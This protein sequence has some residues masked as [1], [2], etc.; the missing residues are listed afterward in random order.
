MIG[1]FGWAGAKR[2]PAKSVFCAGDGG[3]TTAGN[4]NLRAR[5][6]PTTVLLQFTKR[7]HRYRLHRLKRSS[8]HLVSIRSD[9]V[10][11]QVATLL[12]SACPSEVCTTPRLRFIRSIC[13]AWSCLALP[14]TC[15]FPSAG[16]GSSCA[17]IAIRFEC[18]RSS[19]RDSPIAVRAFC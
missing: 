13:S 18:H 17:A 12:A 7:L 4:D 6:Q 14:G 3:R 5:K 8:R 19:T 16:S 11:T 2:R 9:A 1:S 10:L 15:L